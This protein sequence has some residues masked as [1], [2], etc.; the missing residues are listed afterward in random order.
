MERG[1]LQ[2]QI[3]ETAK[4]YLGTPYIWG[5]ESICGFDCSGLVKY[6]YFQ[7]GIDIPRTS[8]EQYKIGISV[9]K[10][11]S[12]LGDLVFFCKLSHVGIY[13]GENQYINAP[14]TGDVVKVSNLDDRNDYVGARRIISEDNKIIIMPNIQP[15]MYIGDF[16]YTLYQYI[17]S[18]QSNKVSI[19][20]GKFAFNKISKLVG[21]HKFDEDSGLLDLNGEHIIVQNFLDELDKKQLIISKEANIDTIADGDG[22]LIEEKIYDDDIILEFA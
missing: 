14:K 5:G 22:Y 16:K 20:C 18:M 15:K 8:Y 10:E 6:V 17:C 19:K 21:Y 11:D 9:E 7:C 13:I 4:N 3:V 2:K 12:E 1:K